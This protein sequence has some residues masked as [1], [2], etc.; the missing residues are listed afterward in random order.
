MRRGRAHH[1]VAPPEERGQG[2]RR[3]AQRAVAGALAPVAPRL[4]QADFGLDPGA[5]R[6]GLLRARAHPSRVSDETV[7]DAINR[8]GLGWKRAKNWI[9]SPDPEYARKKNDAIG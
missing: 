7:R 5:R 2:L 1:A 8:L 4:R 3:R 9:A 6:R